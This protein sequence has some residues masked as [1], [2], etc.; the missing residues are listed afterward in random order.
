M[1]TMNIHFFINKTY[2]H[3]NCIP[4]PFLPIMMFNNPNDIQINS[5]TA[6]QIWWKV[7]F[8]LLLF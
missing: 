1:M 6:Q 8:D 4:L 3:I 5:P 7:S 2:I